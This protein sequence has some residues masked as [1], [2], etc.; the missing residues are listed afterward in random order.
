MKMNLKRIALMLI[1]ICAT[2]NAFAQ[3]QSEGKPSVFVDYFYHPSNV[4]ESWVEAL[5]NK[6]LEG[7]QETQRV[8]ITDVDS[9]AA[10][11]LE[12]SRREEGELSAGGDADRLS[13]MSKLGANYLI[14]GVVTSFS[15]EYKKSSDGNSHWYTASVNYTIKV[16]NPKDGTTIA[17][18]NF[19]HGNTITEMSTGNTEDEAAVDITK[20]ARKDMRELVNE[21]FKLMVLSLRSTKAKVMKQNKYTSA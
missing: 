1:C 5:R 4:P 15:T 10:L 19:K 16:I 13:T 6:V 8:I 11:K 18:E 20:F 9:E 17:S 21:A 14:Q 3:K 2:F 12:K 7:L